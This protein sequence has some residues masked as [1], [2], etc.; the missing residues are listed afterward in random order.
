M[1]TYDFSIVL[2]ETYQERA[3]EL[4]RKLYPEFYPCNTKS[5]AGSKQHPD[6]KGLPSKYIIFMNKRKRCKK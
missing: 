1:K 4:A 3:K 5:L 2:Q 6:I